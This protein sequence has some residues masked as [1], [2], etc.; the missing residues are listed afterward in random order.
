MGITNFAILDLACG[1][2]N[3]RTL[4]PGAFLV[5]YGAC[6]IITEP[7]RRTIQ[8]PPPGPSFDGARV[9]RSSTPGELSELACQ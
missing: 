2:W 7:D 5:A 6:C 9:V 3:M 4:A 1:V 8:W